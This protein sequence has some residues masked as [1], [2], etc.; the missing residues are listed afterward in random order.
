MSLPSSPHEYRRQTSERSGPPGYVGNDEL[1]STW[2]KVL[3]SPMF[4][5]KPLLP[6]E[7][8]SIDFSELTVRTRVGIGKHYSF[9]NILCT[10]VYILA[11]PPLPAFFGTMHSFCST[12]MDIGGLGLAFFAIKTVPEESDRPVHSLCTRVVLIS[13]CILHIFFLAQEKLWTNEE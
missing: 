7:E 13:D 10:I 4:Q 1:V 9:F 2:N 6:Y 11:T 8:W 3:E 12:R 5:N